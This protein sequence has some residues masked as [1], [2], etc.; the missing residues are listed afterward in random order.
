MFQKLSLWHACYYALDLNTHKVSAKPGYFNTV[1]NFAL[2][3]R[4]VSA[5]CTLS[6]LGATETQG[7]RTS[8]HCPAFAFSVALIPSTLW[9]AVWMAVVVLGTG[10][11]DVEDFVLGGRGIGRAEASGWIP[12]P[13]LS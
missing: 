2:P 6:Y 7:Q 4:T 8:N 12:V 9:M 5:L 11:C 13:A 10:G 1:H 3:K